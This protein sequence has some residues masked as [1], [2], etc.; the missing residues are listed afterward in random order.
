MNVERAAALVCSGF[1]GPGGHG[2]SIINGT[3]GTKSE[4]EEEKEKET[5]PSRS[6]RF[7]SEKG[8]G[9]FEVR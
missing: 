4:E 9:V 8:S 3:L 1:H 6:S 5:W 7:R 2:F